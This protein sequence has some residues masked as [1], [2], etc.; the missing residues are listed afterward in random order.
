MNNKF[1][2]KSEA[3]AIQYYK[4]ESALLT[5]DFSE[6]K[7]GDPVKCVMRG[8][9]A[10]GEIRLDHPMPI[11]VRFNSGLSN[12][13]TIDGRYSPTLSN[14]T[15]FYP[16]SGQ[17]PTA[18]ACKRPK[19]DPY[20]LHGV[21]R[22]QVAE[23]AKAVELIAGFK[24]SVLAW[25]KNGKACFHYK[26]LDRAVLAWRTMGGCTRVARLKKESHYEHWKTPIILGGES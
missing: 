1:E 20:E 18:D 8:D 7:V 9:G 19:P 23:L 14:P 13:Y 10:V 26:V 6:L 22:E 3:E 21:T 12:T 2:S 24:P 25:N 15:L 16:F 11:C 5:P 4:P 17:F